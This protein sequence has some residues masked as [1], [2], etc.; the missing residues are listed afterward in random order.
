M[1]EVTDKDVR[2]SC[3]CHNDK[4]ASRRVRFSGQDGFAVSVPLCSNCLVELLEGILSYEECAGK[5]GAE[6]V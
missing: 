4:E 1:I 3:Y 6:G 2:G 5:R